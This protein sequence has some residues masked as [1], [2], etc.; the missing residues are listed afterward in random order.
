MCYVADHR[1]GIGPSDAAQ[2]SACHLTD[3]SCSQRH[4]LSPEPAS[5]ALFRAL[6]PQKLFALH[7]AYSVSSDVIHVWAFVLGGPPEFV[8]RCRAL[9]SPEERQRADRF[10]FEHDR[11]RHTVAHAVTRH[12]L[13]RC[14]WSTASGAVS[15]ESLRF[16]TTSA[17]KPSLQFPSAAASSIQF[18]LT[19]SEDRGLLA[20]SSGLELGV[21]LER[22]R[23]NIEALAISR[24]YFFGTER[25]AIES[26]PPELT[27]PTFFRYWVA[28]EAVLKA[29]GIGLGFPL[30]RFRVDFLPGGD[31]ATI[32]TLDPERLEAGWSIRMLS[33]EPG[34]L[35]AVAARGDRWEIALGQ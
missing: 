26:A 33:C 7:D 19:H 14:C 5:T 24:H 30:D 4:F 22:V 12:L 13:S 2:Y 20:V 17:G 3:T 23:S 21:D 32:E 10:V 27:E 8:A 34:W 28:K 16:S 29:Q 18:N 9:L 25:A 1:H 11:I 31:R 35:G 6:D 15:P